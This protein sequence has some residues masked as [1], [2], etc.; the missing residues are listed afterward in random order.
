MAGNKLPAG[1]VIMCKLTAF[2]ITEDSDIDCIGGG[3]M[4]M[5]YQASSQ[6][7]EFLNQQVKKL[8]ME[9]SQGFSTNIFGALTGSR[10]KTRRKQVTS[11]LS[12]PVTTGSHIPATPIDAPTSKTLSEDVTQAELE[13]RPPA[14]VP[15]NEEPAEKSS[16]SSQLGKSYVADVQH[17]GKHIP[18]HCTDTDECKHLTN[19]V[20]EH[21]SNEVYNMFKD[22]FS[23]VNHD[24]IQETY[25][26]ISIYNQIFMQ[27]VEKTS[28][29]YVLDLKFT[30][31]EAPEVDL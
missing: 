10:C 7:F 11:I 19:H 14:P 8:H 28:F 31:L 18:F 15:L 24:S 2:A 1:P 21:L 25:P 5:V 9:R 3:K 26:K 12:T 13:A 16:T 6:Y 29:K 23:N 17:N 22:L 4:E 20:N 30:K 27:F